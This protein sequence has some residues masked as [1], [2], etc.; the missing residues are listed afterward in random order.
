MSARDD[1]LRSIRRQLPLSAPLPTE[2]FA[3]VQ[4]DHPVQQFLQVL[5][6]VGGQGHLLTSPDQIPNQ[7]ARQSLGTTGRL[8]SA[9]PGVLEPLFDFNSVSDPHTLA[10]VELTIL[11]GELAVAE[12]AA[13]WIQTSSPAQRTACFLSQHLALVVPVSR[14]VHNLHDAYRQLQIGDQSFGCWISGPSKTADIEQS[15]VKGAHGARTLNVF[16]IES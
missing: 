1:I 8:L 10:D 16:L 14:I 15:L 4:Y 11:P 6:S 7:L 13:V 12:N 2:T 9:V 5:E 3:G